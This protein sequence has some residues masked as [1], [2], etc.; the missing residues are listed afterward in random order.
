MKI[1]K[2]K[3]IQKDLMVKVKN[4]KYVWKEDPI[5]LDKDHADILIKR[6]P[7][8]FEIVKGSEKDYNPALDFNKDGKNDEKD[9]SLGAKAMAKQRRK[10]GGD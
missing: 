7:G 5:E 1:V 8:R 10:K 6:F 3:S 2:V 9:A 4:M